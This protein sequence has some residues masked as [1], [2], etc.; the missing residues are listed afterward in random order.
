[1]PDTASPRILLADDHGLIRDAL[2]RAIRKKIPTAQFEKVSNAFEAEGAIVATDF[3][4]VVLDLGLPGAGELETLRR[5]RVLRPHLPILVFTSFSEEK[6]GRAALD[7]GAN[8]FLAKTAD[9]A[10][11]AIAASETL[12]GR[13]YVSEKLKELRTSRPPF[14]TSTHSLSARELEVLTDLGRG[15]GQKEI[16]ARLG[17]SVPS[18]ATYRARIMEKLRL[19]TT[20]DLLRYVVENRLTR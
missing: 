1:M 16:A 8:G 2:P 17:V 19:R 18:V 11:I 13:G 14:G 3:D 4:L 10:L 5:L 7:A 6:M 9:P 20:A 12:A 15:L